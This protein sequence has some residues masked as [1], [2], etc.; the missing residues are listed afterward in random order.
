MGMEA[1]MWL[2][3]YFHG[4]KTPGILSHGNGN[5]KEFYFAKSVEPYGCLGTTPSDSFASL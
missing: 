2:K 1:V 4:F 5:I 3:K